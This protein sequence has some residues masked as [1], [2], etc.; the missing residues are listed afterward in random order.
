MDA[1]SRSIDGQCV[2]VKMAGRMEETLQAFAVR[3]ARL[4]GELERLRTQQ[5]DGQDFGATHLIAVSA[6][7]LRVRCGPAGALAVM[8]QFRGLGMAP[9]AGKSPQPRHEP[10]LP[11]AI[12]PPGSRWREP[13]GR[14]PCGFACLIRVDS[15][16]NN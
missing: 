8:R 5:F 16:Q 14:P 9:A 13:A 11:P 2:I 12:H 7:S 1:E 3:A 10:R 6:R 15:L 4:I